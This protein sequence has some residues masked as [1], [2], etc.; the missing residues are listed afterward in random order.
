M[1]GEDWH[2]YLKQVRDTPKKN[3][4]ACLS[5]DSSKDD[6]AKKCV[7]KQPKVVENKRFSINS[8]YKSRTD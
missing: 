7:E 5:R 8:N 2:T 3:C 6:E 1:I 4:Q